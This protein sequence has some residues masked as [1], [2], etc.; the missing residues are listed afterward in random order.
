[1]GGLTNLVKKSESKEGGFVAMLIGAAG[2]LGATKLG[3][4]LYKESS[5]GQRITDYF[6]G[7]TTPGFGVGDALDL[8]G[9]GIGFA[10]GIRG[11]NPY[12]TVGLGFLVS[13]LPDM[14]YWGSM[15]GHEAG[16]NFEQLSGDLGWDF[17]S[18][19]QF[20]GWYGYKSRY[21]W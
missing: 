14:V 17:A 8:A 6:G 9:G 13:G 15:A 7:K 19:W 10:G 2:V 4:T 5:I 11:S 3:T 21:C 18:C 16:Y 20:I 1:M 12:G